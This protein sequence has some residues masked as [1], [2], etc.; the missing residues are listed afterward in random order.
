MDKNYFYHQF[1]ENNF[2]EDF[3]PLSNKVIQGDW[4]YVDKINFGLQVPHSKRIYDKHRGG[5]E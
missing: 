2:L 1:G 5:E 4:W 3:Y